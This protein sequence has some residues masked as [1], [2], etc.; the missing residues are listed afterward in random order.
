[1]ANK[2]LSYRT[3]IPVRF[4]EADPLGVVWHGH[5]LRYFE[6]GREAFGKEYGLAYLDF[7]HHGLAVPVVSAH[8]DYKRPLRYG[9]SMIVETIYESTPAAKLIF[10]YKIF[11]KQQQ[12]LIA[13][14]TTTQVFVDVKTFD[15]HLTMPPFFEGWRNQR[16]V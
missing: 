8:C 13:T 15:L 7:Y 6:D 9:D 10:H 2:I 14:G 3:D 11:S 1:M 16:G 4:N 5:Y 12:E